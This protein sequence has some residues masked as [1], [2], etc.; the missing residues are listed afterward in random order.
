MYAGTPDRASRLP[1]VIKELYRPSAADLALLDAA[2]AGND[3]DVERHLH[4]GAHPNALTVAGGKYP[5]NWTPLHLASAKGSVRCVSMLLAAGA[6]VEAKD[7]EGR[8]P[9]MCADVASDGVL[10]AL[11]AA[12]ADVPC[13]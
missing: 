10:L 7:D 2:A 1:V 5:A 9:L 3:V 11:L 6:Q 12:S 13:P 8:T 4:R